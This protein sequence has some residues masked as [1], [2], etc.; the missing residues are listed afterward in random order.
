MGIEITGTLT[1]QHVN[2]PAVYPT[3]LKNGTVS[4]AKIKTTWKHYKQFLTL[5][6]QNPEDYKEEM[7]LKLAD[8]EWFRETY[9]YRN[10]ETVHRIWSTCVLPVASKIKKAYNPKTV[11]HPSLYPWNCK[12]CQ[13]KSL[14]QAELRDYDVPAII[15][16]EYTVRVRPQNV[17]PEA[18]EVSSLAS[19]T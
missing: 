19:D 14:C 2:T 11:N 8:I 10:P 18:S 7:V 9:E 15:Q 17:S 5:N 12:M 3:L 16:R 6:N 4:R 13:Y 1:W